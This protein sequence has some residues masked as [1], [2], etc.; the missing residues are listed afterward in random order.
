MADHDDSCLKLP[1]FKRSKHVLVFPLPAQGHMSG[2]FRLSIA[3]AKRGVTVSVVAVERHIVLLRTF[4]E[5]QALD[6]FN[7]IPYENPEEEVDVLKF[8]D[9]S[10][11][12]SRPVFDK[13]VENRKAGL[14]GPTCI[15]GD[16]VLTWLP[17][18]A[19]E[20]NVHYYQFSSFGAV[21]IRA[22][23]AYSQLLADGVLIVKEVGPNGI[24]MP[25]EFDGLLKIPGLPALK[26]GEMANSS[27]QI[28]ISKAISDTVAKADAV[29][30]NTFYELESSVI[31]SIR[32]SWLD[33][34][35]GGKIHKLFPVGPLSNAASFKDRCFVEHLNS[36]RP[37]CLKWLDS[38]PPQSV[39]YICVGSVV[40]LSSD[41]I[42]ELALAM[43]GSNLS[44]LWATNK[45]SEG[46][47]PPGFQER[48][49]ANI[50][51]VWGWVPQLQILGHSSIGG[52][53]TH[54]GWNSIIE[55]VTSGVPM[56]AWPQLGV[57]QFT[58]CRLLVDVLKVATEVRPQESSAEDFTPLT[59]ESIAP[60]LLCNPNQL[61]SEA[62]ESAL[63]LLM[64]TEEG[65]AM[66][67][68]VQ[69]LKK[70]AEATVEDGG[71][72]A[73]ALDDL[74]ENIPA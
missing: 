62:F 15:I 26:H 20:L 44:F 35:T 42:R 32:Q 10:R 18:T 49:K 21:Y 36:Q 34:S 5:V 2:M 71:G 6:N 72:S 52:F 57:D 68:R 56:V 28:E 23:Q 4:D 63:R 14:P 7:L 27:I 50:M 37:D 22:L 60:G 45:G 69:E 3:L 13:L 30:V 58:N 41:Q 67:C 47:L 8:L 33:H 48:T 9:I 43:E 53:L 73:N 59:V 61:T 38:R 66:R 17:D 46:S 51:I 19:K 39:V 1:Q 16:S 40:L 55:S 24:R 54:C 31:D 70:K 65:H 29:V 74:A 25:A 12:L 11:N 64:S